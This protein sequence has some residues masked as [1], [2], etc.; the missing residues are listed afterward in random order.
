MER[1]K[2][3]ITKRIEDELVRLDRVAGPVFNL[4]PTIARRKAALGQLAVPAFRI[5]GSTRGPLYVRA[6]DLDRLVAERYEA[7][8]KLRKTASAAD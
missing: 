7:A 3:D 1:L 4:K 5:N 8:A 6:S 2:M